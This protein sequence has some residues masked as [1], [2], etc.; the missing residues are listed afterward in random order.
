MSS[1]R[2]AF[3]GGILSAGILVTALI[4][5]CGDTEQAFG[6][7]EPIQQPALDLNENVSETKFMGEGIISVAIPIMGEEKEIYDPWIA[8]TIISMLPEATLIRLLSK[9]SVY[10]NDIELASA[11]T[12]MAGVGSFDVSSCMLMTEASW[13]CIKCCFGDPPCC[14]PCPA[15][16]AKD[17]DKG[18]VPFVLY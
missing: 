12:A 13:G 17:K 1:K 5:S 7:T 9:G 10:I 8:E 2:L 4:Y 11:I 18:L 14:T 15:C 3:V 16:C 6:P